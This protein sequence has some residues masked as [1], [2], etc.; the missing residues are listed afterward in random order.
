MGGDLLARGRKIADLRRICVRSYLH[1]RVM[2]V[3]A[4]KDWESW[5]FGNGLPARVPQPPFELT[6]PRSLG[7]RATPRLLG[8]HPRWI[9]CERSD[10]HAIWRASNRQVSGCSATAETP[11]TAKDATHSFGQAARSH[12]APQ[13]ARMLK[14]CSSGCPC[15][16]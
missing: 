15:P 6:K 5:M 1:S 11:A 3:I 16:G 14:G 4:D 7:C 12:G 10:R 13:S 2:I 9:E 8:R